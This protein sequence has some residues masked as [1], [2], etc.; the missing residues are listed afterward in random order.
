[1]SLMPSFQNRRTSSNTTKIET[2]IRL[3]RCTKWFS[4]R[5]DA[6]VAQGVFMLCLCD[7]THQEK[8]KDAVP[9]IFIPAYLEEL[10]Q[11]N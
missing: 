5:A 6:A 4:N 1:M 10:R 8:K 7:Y 11:S 2:I 3:M 9:L